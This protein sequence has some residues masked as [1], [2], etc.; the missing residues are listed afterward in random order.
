M[1]VMKRSPVAAPKRDPRTGRWS[2]VL[3]AG[4][5]P[6]TG[7]RQQVRRRGFATKKEAAVELDRLLYHWVDTSVPPAAMP[8]WLEDA[9]RPSASPT[10]KPIPTKLAARRSDAVS[11]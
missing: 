11:Y 7:K 2:F 3:D 6:A 9:L 5:D 1:R 4:P 8:R 10:V